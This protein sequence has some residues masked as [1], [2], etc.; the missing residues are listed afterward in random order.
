MWWYPQRFVT[1]LVS[2]DASPFVSTGFL[3]TSI[4]MTS[5]ANHSKEAK[6]G[7]DK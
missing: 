5:I 1:S 4:A 3:A 7:V 6:A 2:A